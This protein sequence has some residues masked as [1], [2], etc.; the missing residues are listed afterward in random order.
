MKQL[1]K[2][3]VNIIAGLLELQRSKPD[4]F[5]A[6]VSW[7]LLYAAEWD[8]PEPVSWLDG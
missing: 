2:F 3:G 6:V 1:I 4:E 5:A 8:D 7:A